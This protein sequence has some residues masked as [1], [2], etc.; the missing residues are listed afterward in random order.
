MKMSCA[1]H[2]EVSHGEGY[3]LL[4]LKINMIPRQL[5]VSKLA[6]R[7]SCLQNSFDEPRCCQGVLTVAPDFRY[8]GGT[9]SG[10]EDICN[11][12]NSPRCWSPFECIFI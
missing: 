5:G 7:R 12:P 8:F 9:L 10:V 2:K 6:C 4:Y 1:Y 11:Y 3:P